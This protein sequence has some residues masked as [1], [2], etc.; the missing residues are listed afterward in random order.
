[1]LESKPGSEPVI[2]LQSFLHP[3]NDIKLQSFSLTDLGPFT[4]RSWFVV[5]REGSNN[6]L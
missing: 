1:M 4:L 2:E 5:Y 3:G 6:D